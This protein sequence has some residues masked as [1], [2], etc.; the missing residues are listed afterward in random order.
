V[1]AL[2]SCYNYHNYIIMA[3]KRT[4]FLFIL[5]G[6]TLICRAQNLPIVNLLVSNSN[7]AVRTLGL[8][9]KYADLSIDLKGK[10]IINDPWAY[11]IYFTNVDGDFLRGKINMVDGVPVKYYDKFD[12]F[13][14]IGKVKSIGDVEIAYYDRFDNS[15]HFGK[16]KTI[17]KTPVTYNDQFDGFDNVGKIKSVGQLKITYY[18]RFDGELKGK[19]K[20]IGDIQITYYDRFNDTSLVGKIKAVTGNTDY[21]NVYKVAPNALYDRND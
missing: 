14:N 15:L 8:P 5:L 1:A 17:G 16:V 7:A 2:L 18:D 4:F 13:D 6:T 9:L 10:L 3:L 20:S 11:V 12:G 21:V 19:F